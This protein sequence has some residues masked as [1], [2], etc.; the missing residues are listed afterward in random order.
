MVGFLC[1]KGLEP[2]FRVPKKT[3]KI[4]ILHFLR[5]NLHLSI[6]FAQHPHSTIATIIFHMYKQKTTTQTL[7]CSTYTDITAK[8]F[9]SNLTTNNLHHFSSLHI[10]KWT[11][12][13]E[14]REQSSP[15]TVHSQNLHILIFS[16]LKP[17]YTTTSRNISFPKQLTV[18][19]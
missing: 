16:L 3:L 13:T 18:H 15:L 8:R 1:R 19:L 2:L 9:S 14:P 6:G 10:Q 12:T 11:L 7:F 17:L 5:G 4:T